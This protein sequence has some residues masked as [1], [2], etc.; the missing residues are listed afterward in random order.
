MRTRFIAASLMFGASSLAAQAPAK[1][2]PQRVADDFVTLFGSH[3]GYRINHSK[4]IVVTG[5]F[6]PSPG[7]TGLSRAAHLT[8]ASTPVIVRFSDGTG[9]PTIPDNSP[10]ASPHGIAVRFTLPT[11]AYTDIVALAHNGF[12]VGTGE[13]FA[14]FLEAAAATKPTS[15]HPTPVEAFLQGHPHAMKFVTDPEPNPVSFGDL[16]WFGNNALVFVNAKGV[17]QPG[18]YKIVPV[19]TPKFLDSAAAAKKGPTYLMDEMTHRLAANQPVK[20][21][22]LVQL[23]NPG[24]PTVDGSVT[25]PDDRKLVELGVI[26]LTTVAPNNA[27]LQRSL[28]FSPIYLTDGIQLGDDPLIEFRAAVY[29]LSV[30]RRR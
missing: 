20:L 6:T 24:D 16:T 3:T 22:L 26:T 14:E 21:R 8:A 5:T 28:A 30:A 18:R 9:L 11:G 15:K 19:E 17:K 12:V 4:G 1:N 7:A 29:A 25:W 13:E 23:A 2:L 27:A 10:Q